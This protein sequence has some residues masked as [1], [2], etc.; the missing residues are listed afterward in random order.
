MQSLGEPESGGTYHQNVAQE[1]DQEQCRQ[2]DDIDGLRLSI[3]EVL[4]WAAG[5][6]AVLDIHDLHRAR[7]DDRKHR[8]DDEEQGYVSQ[9]EAGPLSLPVLLP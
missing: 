2:E 5:V 9:Q 6:V 1:R 3:E 4:P 7:L 8:L